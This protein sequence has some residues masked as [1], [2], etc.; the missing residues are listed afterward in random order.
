LED[1]NED[2]DTIDALQYLYDLIDDELGGWSIYTYTTTPSS[3]RYVAPNGKVYA[4]SYNSTTKLYT[5]PDFMFPKTFTTLDAMKSYIDVNNGGWGSSLWTAS[6]KWW[7]HTVDTSWQAS[8]YTAP[9]GKVYSFF[10]TTD[11]RYA[12]YNFISAKYFDSPQSM[13]MYININNPR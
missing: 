2:Q 11:N 13:I 7:N 10:K 1:D 6:G 5:S 9:N 12:S 8:P 4:I 3:D